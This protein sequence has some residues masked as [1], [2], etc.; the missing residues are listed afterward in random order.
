MT[1][2]H[3]VGARLACV[4]FDICMSGLSTSVW[5][6]HLQHLRGLTV[7]SALCL[8]LEMLTWALQR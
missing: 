4:V 6:D 1:R 3:P 2:T 8:S 5:S 7:L